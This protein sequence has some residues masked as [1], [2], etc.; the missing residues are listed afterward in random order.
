MTPTVT[1]SSTPPLTLRRSS[2]KSSGCVPKWKRSDQK[3]LTTWLK[4]PSASAKVKV[5][6]R[7]VSARCWTRPECSGAVNTA[8]RKA[9]EMAP[10][11][12][13]NLK[14]VSEDHMSRYVRSPD[15]QDVKLSLDGNLFGI[16]VTA[17][18][19]EIRGQTAS[20]NIGELEATIKAIRAVAE[21]GKGDEG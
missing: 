8:A 15:P 5:S 4:K 19:I 1:S 21:G 3:P 10:K 14:D 2:R 11:I 13:V 16:G 12:V 18:S 9:T 6:Q 17:V 20:V 7:I